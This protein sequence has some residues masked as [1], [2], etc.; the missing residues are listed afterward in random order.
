MSYERLAKPAVRPDRSL[1]SITGHTYPEKSFVAYV[2]NAIRQAGTNGTTSELKPYLLKWATDTRMLRHAWNELAANGGEAPGPNGRRYSDLESEDVWTLLRSISKSARL[3]MYAPAPPK[4]VAIPKNIFRPELG[5]RELC[6][7]NIEDR[8]LQR[9]IATLLQPLVDPRLSDLVFGSRQRGRLHA[10]AK[11]EQLAIVNGRWVWVIEDIRNAFDSVPRGQL[12]DVLA[13]LVPSGELIELIIKLVDNGQRHG[14]QQ[15]GPLASMMLTVYLRIMLTRPWARQQPM[16]PQ[17][18]YVDDTATV[19]RTKQ[20][21]TESWNMQRQVLQSA[22]MQLKGCTAASSTKDLRKGE[23]AIWLGFKLWKVGDSLKVGIADK[24]WERLDGKL[25]LAHDEPNAPLVAAATIKGW[26]DQMGPCYASEDRP[27]VLD[28]IQEAASKLG[29]DE[30]PT[31]DAL[32]MRWSRAHE[33]WCEL[34]E[35]VNSP[36]AETFEEPPTRA[37]AEADQAEVP[38]NATP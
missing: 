24:S 26:L 30:L 33:R 3:G 28:R 37:E 2:T 18:R 14:V 34:R 20:E 35:T 6:L 19:C 31:R 29:Y 36:T 7:I 16:V 23:P 5:T 12:K 17:F 1:K 32:R 27:A 38:F 4:R 21:A 15:G 25:L 10:L 22:G 11:L 9:A 8:A 13:R